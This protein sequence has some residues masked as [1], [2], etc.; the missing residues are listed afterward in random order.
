MVCIIIYLSLAMQGHWSTSA[1]DGHRCITSEAFD[2][3]SRWST[4]QSIKFVDFP[5][6]D[7]TYHEIY[8]CHAVLLDCLWG[9]Q[10]L[11]VLVSPN[12]GAVLKMA[13][14]RESE[15]FPATGKTHASS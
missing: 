6:T 2:I 14:I 9:L 15:Q 13:K 7:P 8:G 12:I 3:S 4:R 1:R 5:L 11:E 10:D